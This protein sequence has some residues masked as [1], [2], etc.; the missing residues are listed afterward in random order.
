MKTLCRKY[1]TIDV[2]ARVLQTLLA[3]AFLILL[4]IVL[5][6]CS[7]QNTVPEERSSAVSTEETTDYSDIE[8]H[9][10][11]IMPKNR[12]SLADEN[13]EFPDWIELENAGEKSVSL[14]GWTISDGK[15]AHRQIMPEHTLAPGEFTIVFCRDFGLSDGENLVLYDPNGKKHA[16]LP[17]ISAAADHS[18]SLRADGSLTE[19]Q[20]ISPG[21]SNGKVGY[22]LWCASS[23]VPSS[24]IIN[25]VAVSRADDTDSAE[26]WAD[27]VEVKNNSTA[28]ID[29]SEYRLSD[30]I[31][32]SA[33][34]TFPSMF[35]QPGELAVFHCDGD[36]PASETNTGFSLNAVYDQLYLY[37]QAGVLLDYAS[38]HDIPVKG[39][40]GRLTGEAGFFYFAAA[41]CNQENSDGLRRVADMPVCLT[42]EGPYNNIGSLSILLQAEG[43]IYYS[44]DS[45][46]PTTTSPYYTDPLTIT[47]TGIIRA[48]SYEE[49]AL[50]S[51]TATF[52]FFLN[53]NHVFPILSLV[54]EDISTFEQMY[55]FGQK[56]PSIPANLALYEDGETK[57][58]HECELTMK[59][60]TSLYLAKKSMGVEFKGR[61]GGNLQ[62][63][64]FN[65]GI[66]EYRSLSLRAGQDYTYSFFRNELFQEL[67]LEASDSLYTQESKYC[68]LYVNGEYYGIYCLKEDFSDQYYA[69]HAGVSVDSVE[70]FRAP[71]AYLSEYNLLV[72]EFGQVADMT[73][74]ENYQKICDSININSLIDWFL[75]ESWCANTDTQGNQRVYRSTENGNR[76]EYVFYDLDWGLWYNEGNFKILLVGIGNVGP[77]MPWLITS[78][79]K[80]TDFRDRVLTRYAE[81]VDTVFA[82]DYVLAKIDDYVAL[83]TPEMPRDRDRWNLTMKSWDDWVDSLR[84]IIRNGYADYTV[85]TLCE[86]LNISSEERA[87][88]FG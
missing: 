14:S 29:L 34:W 53:E 77:E 41:S 67:C 36:L 23:P 62:C 40:M 9:I 37:D 54:T 55:T 79:L 15:K 61:Y 44:L 59:G 72:Q 19:S 43:T 30:N 76:W 50:P 4:G 87:H 81:L 70:G 7:V 12:A 88:Y 58:S 66:T 21:Y 10:S 75:F 85:D 28:V 18:L 35:L 8:L 65:N 16:E 42:A 25:E 86:C 51:R 13:G 31:E 1:N 33:L 6:G 84:D 39:S 32:E 71:A 68:I 47:E 17:C 27:W 82:D 69:S 20:W 46:I 48:V 80:N 3:G 64:V 78:L 45:S 63:D 38:L 56:A 2:L 22:D 74:P 49:G 5:C 73:V 57:F 26:E 11:E 83:L 52:S 60:W 24:L